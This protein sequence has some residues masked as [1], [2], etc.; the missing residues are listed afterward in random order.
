MA[1]KLIFT[2]HPGSLTPKQFAEETA[3]W[4]TQNEESRLWE[5]ELQFRRVTP[6]LSA[7]E[8]CLLW[9]AAMK[10]YFEGEGQ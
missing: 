2:S 6:E 1:N 4:L 3:S 7:G 5:L 8:A 10:L 9:A